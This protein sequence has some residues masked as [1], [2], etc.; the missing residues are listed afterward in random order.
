MN[1][2]TF[3]KRLFN[4]FS[5]KELPNLVYLH[6]P[7]CGG[8]S[9]DEAI[10][11]QYLS[12]NKFKDKLIYDRINSLNSAYVGSLTDGLNFPD[13]DPFNNRNMQFNRDYVA[14]KMLSSKT[15]YISGHFPF[16]SKLYKDFENKFDYFTLMRDPV[17]KWL[18]NYLYRKNR[19]TGSTGE[20]IDQGH[21]KINLDI[22]NYLNSERGHFHGYDYSKYF[23]G[24]R[25]NYDYNSK[26]AIQNA[27]KNLSKFKIIGFLEDLESLKRDFYQ[28]Y[29]FVLYFPH[30]KKSRE[31]NDTN[32]NNDLIEQI[33]EVCQTDIEI[34]D[35][36]RKLVKKLS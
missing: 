32:V 6:I 22:E 3:K 16:N 5:S 1:F 7:K 11:S 28:H 34:Y 26:E 13:G 19:L 17:Q 15:K 23:G 20:M 18:S 31:K 14:Y 36:A 33:K 21:W 4:S 35:Y 2:N 27:K 8:T 12:L 9:I 25:E 10:R 30:M 29:K 24:I